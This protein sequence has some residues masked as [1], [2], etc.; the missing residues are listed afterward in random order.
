MT[1]AVIV[2]AN[3]GWP[4]DVTPMPI[5]GVMPTQRV[6]AGAEMTFYVQSGQDL[7][8]HEVQPAE[9]AAAKERDPNLPADAIA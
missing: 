2:K 3:H 8:I 5:D 6:P 4:V 1:T 9:I 7:L